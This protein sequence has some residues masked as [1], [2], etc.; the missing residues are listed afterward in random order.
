MTIAREYSVDELERLVK[1]HAYCLTV[2][3]NVSS[4]LKQSAAQAVADYEAAKAKR[5]AENQ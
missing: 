2:N 3:G 1:L 4:A 5:D